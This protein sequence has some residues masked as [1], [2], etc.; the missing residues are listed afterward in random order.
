[1][2]HIDVEKINFNPDL[3][4]VMAERPQ[5]VPKKEPVPKQNGID[6]PLARKA[7]SSRGFAPESTVTRGKP[8]S[9]FATSGLSLIGTNVN[10]NPLA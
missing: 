8:P 4:P 2:Q 1:M 6:L 5:I 3:K 7:S 10:Q 9:I